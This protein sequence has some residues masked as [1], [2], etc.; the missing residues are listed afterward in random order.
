MGFTAVMKVP[1]NHLHAI[2]EITANI[3]FLTYS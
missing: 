1:V 3:A 2:A